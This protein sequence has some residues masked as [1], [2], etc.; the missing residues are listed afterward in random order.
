GGERLDDLARVQ[1]ACLLRGTAALLATAGRSL[2]D[3]PAGRFS[4]AVTEAIS[5]ITG[6]SSSGSGDLRERVSEIANRAS[7]LAHPEDAAR[8]EGRLE[9]LLTTVKRDW[10]ERGA[11]GLVAPLRALD[12]FD[13][14]ELFPIV[15]DAPRDHVTHVNA[16]LSDLTNVGGTTLAA[17]NGAL[18]SLLLKYAWCV[19]HRGS[20]DVSIHDHTR[21]MCAIAATLWE[22]RDA[23]DQ[24][25]AIIGGDV[26]GVQAFLY[27]ISSSGALKGLRGRSFYLQLIEEAV[28]RFLLREWNLPDACRIMEG[29]GHLYILAPARVL[30]SLPE[31]RTR[32][33]EAFIDHHDADL[34]VAIAGTGISTDDL[35]DANSIE[36]RFAEVNEKLGR[37]KRRRGEGLS[38]SRMAQRLFKARDV[39]SQDHQ[40]CR[41]C[42]R[43]ISDAGSS[44]PSQDD[45]ERRTCALCLSLED[46]GHRLRQGSTLVMWHSP[47]T[48]SAVTSQAETAQDDD[49]DR[50]AWGSA[51][52]NGVLG[53][54]GLEIRVLRNV[55]GVTR[56]GRP[57][58]PINAQTWVLRLQGTDV[59]QAVAD[60]ASLG[61]DGAVPGFRL[62]AQAT[63]LTR[64]GRQVADFAEL[65]DAA[66]G[67]KYIGFLRADVDNLGDTILR[68]LHTTTSDGTAMNRGTL[69]RRVALSMSLRLFFEGHLSR[70]C[71]KSQDNG[72]ARALD[73]LFLIYAGGDDLFIA[74][75][76]DAVARVA[77]EISEAF[78]KYAGGNPAVHLSAGL[79]MGHAKYPISAGARDALEAQDKA[80]GYV[81][82]PNSNGGAGRAKDAIHLLDRTIGWETFPA[83]QALANE[84]VDAVRDGSGSAP[85][86][87][88]RMALELVRMEGSE[89]VRQKSLDDADA[90]HAT[91]SG[92]ARRTPRLRAG[93]V[94]GGRW[95]ALA[96]YQ[97]TRAKESRGGRNARVRPDLVKRVHELLLT[98]EGIDRLAIA[99]T[100]AD[101]AIR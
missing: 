72:P 4:V 49:D 46:L 92:T 3:L 19:P 47:D 57:H 97:M 40:F 61:L 48:A 75:A 22:L 52:W 1:L 76:W 25:L 24:R 86:S 83:A 80:K 71:R 44:I 8:D 89:R 54:L 37:A 90:S 74:G 85:R 58:V 55:N 73:S 32:L 87:F 26:S 79:A 78:R 38:A 14:D 95:L 16:F 30:D 29:G 59:V 68:G 65:A 10:R 66:S 63:P 101:L 100:W 53:A 11:R 31:V 36:A 42:D 9:P 7:Y 28:G 96:A 64:D 88:I 43:S 93:Q 94:A 12:Q 33:A 41:V 51:A 6:H 67:S 15:S 98:P 84:L 81:R 56:R 62:L 35:L 21:V 18:G 39:G 91:S 27:R 69:A 5:E 20:R 23:T 60:A 13:D 50:S 17:F 99:A 77:G 34:F 2:S 82:P 45:R 70:L